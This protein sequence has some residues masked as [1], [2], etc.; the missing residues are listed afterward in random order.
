MTNVPSSDDLFEAGRETM[1]FAWSICLGPAVDLQNSGYDSY[2]PE[3]LAGYWQ[4]E[5]RQRIV[6]LTLI[7]LASELYLK[8]KIAEVSPYLL[9]ADPPGKW[10]RSSKGV[11][12]DFSELR[13]ID[14]QDL[15]GAF[16][17]AS[18]DSLSDEF[19]T[20]FE[21]LRKQRNMGIHSTGQTLT[22]TTAEVVES[23]LFVQK[24]IFP[25]EPWVKTRRRFLDSDRWSHLGGNEWTTNGLAAEVDATIEI[26]KPAQSK[27]YFKVTKRDRKYMC[28]ECYMAANRDSDFEVK[29]AVLKS[30]DRG[31]KWLYCPVCAEELEL[32]VARIPCE[33]CGDSLSYT[34][35]G[36]LT[37]RC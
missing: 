22:P 3:D 20:R 33:D 7:Q 2:D 21:S 10:K 16:S 4:S 19:Q 11:A 26:L 24:E 27:K 28:P 13:T 9:L 17:A 8:A 12:A 29:L 18:G 25:L 14:A 30:G 36:C 34:D 32:E 1:N 23:L 37:C 5:R 31:T 35:Y 15:L 6:A